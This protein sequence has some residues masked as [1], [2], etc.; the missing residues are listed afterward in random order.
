MPKITRARA[1]CSQLRYFFSLKMPAGC[2]STKSGHCFRSFSVSFRV[3]LRCSKLVTQKS[4][5]KQF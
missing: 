2:M 1:E 4:I 3:Y 5:V